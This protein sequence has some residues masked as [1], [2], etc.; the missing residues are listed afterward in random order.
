MLTQE[1]KKSSRSS[2]A[3]FCVKVRRTDAGSVVVGDTKTDE[4]ELYFSPA[5]WFAFIGGVKDGEFD[6]PA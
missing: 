3:N 1:W 4:A 5:E 2:E 6:L